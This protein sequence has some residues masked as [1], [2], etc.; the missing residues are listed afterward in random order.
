MEYI[1]INAEQID[2]LKLL[3]INYKQEIGETVP[4]QKDMES[5]KQ[6]IK[7]GQIY[8]YGCVHEGKLIACCSI[9]V[10][11]STFDY[12]KSGVFEDFYILPKYRH[13]GIA[14]TLVQYAHRSSGVS[15]LIVGCADC[16]MAMYNS[17]G[18]CIS[19]GNMLAYDSQQLGC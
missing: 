16:D 3:Q 14:K 2:E 6:A 15:S 18:F 12:N 5:L 9:S 11:Y 1:N 13:Q 4:T 8:F 7:N 10:T 17:L 19:I